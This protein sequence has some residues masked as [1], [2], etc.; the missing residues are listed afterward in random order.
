VRAQP[1]VGLPSC[2]DLYDR[3]AVL[4]EEHIVAAQFQAGATEEQARAAAALFLADVDREDWVEGCERNNWDRLCMLQSGDL[5][6]FAECAGVREIP[7]DPPADQEADQEPDCAKMYDHLAGI[8][9]SEVDARLQQELEAIPEERRSTLREQHK[10]IISRLTGALDELKRAM[11]PVCEQRRDQIDLECLMKATS[12]AQVDG[13]RGSR[14][15]IPS[16]Q[17]KPEPQDE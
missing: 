11:T 8:A 4:T 14:L 7:K 17:P 13:C 6:G 12:G 1:T 3:M 10:Q 15:I 16:A 2:G 5:T 9:K